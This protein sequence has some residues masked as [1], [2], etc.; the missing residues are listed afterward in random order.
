MRFEFISRGGIYLRVA[1]PGWSDPLD[2]IYSRA[3]GGR[4]NPPGSFSVLYLNAD[5]ETARANV[6]RRFD[7]LPYGVLDLLD[8]RRPVLVSSEVPRQVFGDVVTDPGC[9]AVGLPATYPRLAGGGEVPHSHCQP[10]G[11]AAKERALAGIAC[12]SAARDKGEE[13]AWFKESSSMPVRRWEFD[14]WYWASPQEE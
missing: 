3:S 4:W 13:L 2:P 11:A 14:D 10:I 8:D 1:D 5:F 12:R 9:E 6:N 7:G